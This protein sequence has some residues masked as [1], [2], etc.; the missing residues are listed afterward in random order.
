MF[1]DESILDQFNEPV[2]PTLTPIPD[3][4]TGEIGGNEPMLFNWYFPIIVN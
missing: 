3:N 1:G 4:V 2:T